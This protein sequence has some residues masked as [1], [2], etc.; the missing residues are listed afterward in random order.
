MTIEDDTEDLPDDVPEDEPEPGR[1]DAPS[2][3]EPA[4]LEEG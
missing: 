3:A 2:E 1:T 4:D